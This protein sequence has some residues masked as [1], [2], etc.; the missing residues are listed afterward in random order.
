MRRAALETTQPSDAHATPPS[1]PEKECF[2]FFTFPAEIRNMIY[3]YAARYPDC[4]D[5]YGVYYR[6]VA[7]SIYSSS[8]TTCSSSSTAKPALKC[9]N[10]HHQHKHHQEQRFRNRPVF[11]TPTILLLCRRITAECLP[12]LHS[13]PLIIDRIPPFH[14]DS[15][16]LAPHHHHHRRR[17]LRRPH[18]H[19]VDGG[20]GLMRLGSFLGRAT[21][22]H[23]RSL[24]VRIGLGEGPLG[25]GWVWRRVLAEL[26]GVL[27]ERN[28]LARLR[29]LVRLCDQDDPAAGPVWQSEWDYYSYILDVRFVLPLNTP[30]NQLRGFFS[31]ASFF[32]FL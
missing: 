25:S 27:S 11:R 28:T 19:P 14:I 24:E 10:P 13:R 15:P 16:P 2:S 31:L 26:L 7:S 30:T 1:L 18:Q 29:V 32:F 20:G 5:L 17:S 3:D 4:M 6:K 21:L 8:T 23:L 22:Q 12:V 9:S